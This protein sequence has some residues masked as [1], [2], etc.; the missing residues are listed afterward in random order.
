MKMRSPTPAP[1]TTQH[2]R[3]CDRQRVAAES[4][5]E[6]NVIV[7]GCEL[8]QLLKQA[9]VPP[10]HRSANQGSTLVYCFRAFLLCMTLCE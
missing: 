5:Y 7:D 10:S 6:I 2:Q 8:T 9:E 4:W 3:R 1:C